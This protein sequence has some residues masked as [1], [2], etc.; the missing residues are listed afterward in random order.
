MILNSNARLTSRSN[1]SNTNTN[2]NSILTLLQL[3]ATPACQ[4]LATTPVLLLLILLATNLSLISSSLTHAATKLLFCR[5]WIS[6]LASVSPCFLLSMHLAMKIA[7]NRLTDHVASRLAS[8]VVRARTAKML[9]HPALRLWTGC[10]LLSTFL[11]DDL[12]T[13]LCD[14][15]RA[16]RQTTRAPI[17]LL[18][19]F[20]P[21]AHL[22]APTRLDSCP[23]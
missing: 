20:L 11:T 17:L 9:S 23:T 7:T 22:P 2:T 5:L 21:P 4:V 19:L 16:Q 15:V 3:G 12:V 13:L 1:T 14:S 10:L 18:A 6:A 8:V